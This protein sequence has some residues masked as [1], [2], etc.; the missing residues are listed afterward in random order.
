MFYQ[1]MFLAVPLALASPHAHGRD[2]R[3]HQDIARRMAGDVTVHDISKR[4][5][6]A[7]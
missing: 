4:F 3:G 7:R 2:A 5:G 6:G 1:L